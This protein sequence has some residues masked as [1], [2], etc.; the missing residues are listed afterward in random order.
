MSESVDRAHEECDQHLSGYSD[1]A[2]HLRER[3]DYRSL[4]VLINGWGD[5]EGRIAYRVSADTPAAGSRWNMADVIS[6]IE[7]SDAGQSTSV[8]VI[9][10]A[11]AIWAI[12]PIGDTWAIPPMGDTRP[13]TVTC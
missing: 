6:S 2:V 10:R 7:R 12:T 8:I 13:P 5:V 1:V 3:V 11:E 9:E 4:A